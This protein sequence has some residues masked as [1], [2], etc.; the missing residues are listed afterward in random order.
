M[1]LVLTPEERAFQEEVRSFIRDRLPDDVRERTWSGARM[2]KE[3][4]AGWEKILNERGLAGSELAGGARGH[5][6]DPSPALP[7]RGGDGGRVRPA[8]DAVRGEHGGAGH[9]RVRNRGAEAPLPPRHPLERRMV[10]PGLLRARGRLRPRVPEDPGGARRGP[11]RR[12]RAEDVDERRAARGLDLLP[13]AH[14][15]G[16]EAAAGDLLPPHRHALAGD[17]RATDSDHGRQRGGQRHLLRGRSRPGGE[18]DRRGRQGLDLR[19]VPARARTHGHCG[20]SLA[21]RPRS[22]GF[23]RLRRARRAMA[24]PSPR[25]PGSASASRR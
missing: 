24:V 18:P 22:G 11:L 21:P 6:L 7:L 13:G 20:G 10:V 17:H 8:A 5:R 3:G 4:Q 19:Q 15:P 25:I 2:D 16:S 14:E 23:A 9:H 12:Q 1:D